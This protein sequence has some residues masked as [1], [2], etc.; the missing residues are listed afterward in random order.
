MSLVGLEINGTRVRGVLGAFGDYPVPLP[1]E[2]PA[3]DLPLA[4]SLEKS[5]IEVGSPAVR[6]Y[7]QRPHL[8]CHDFLAALENGAKTWQAG[9]HRLDA[10][11]AMSV[12]WQR[13]EPMC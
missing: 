3:Q 7:R 11:K 9:K 2:P 1:L 12:V 8:V 13:L 6:L 10:A 5:A 4:L